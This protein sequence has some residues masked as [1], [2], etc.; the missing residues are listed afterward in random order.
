MKLG[1][2]QLQLNKFSLEDNVIDVQ[3]GS[4]QLRHS[5]ENG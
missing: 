1:D 2:L 5:A 3:T 4:Y